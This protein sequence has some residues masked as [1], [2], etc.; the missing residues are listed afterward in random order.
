[1]SLDE[2]RR[3][4]DAICYGRAGRGATVAEAIQPGPE[5]VA[6]AV[7]RMRLAAE[8]FGIDRRAAKEA[9][10]SVASIMVTDGFAD[11]AGEAEASLRRLQRS[12]VVDRIA[13][14]DV[15]GAGPRVGLDV[16]VR[17]VSEAMAAAWK[18]TR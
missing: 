6:V 7:R 9:S 16:D 18:G 4:Q 3:T 11:V 10:N 2:D 14:K 1:V 12:A 17:A 13:G 5:S 8:A 15:V